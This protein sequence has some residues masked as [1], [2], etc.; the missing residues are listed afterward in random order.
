MLIAAWNEG[1]IDFA[2][3]PGCMGVFVPECPYVRA[4]TK[5][6]WEMANRGVSLILSD[7]KGFKNLQ[8]KPEISLFL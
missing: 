3:L 8:T 4:A 2:L 5:P 1:K 7:Y 6:M